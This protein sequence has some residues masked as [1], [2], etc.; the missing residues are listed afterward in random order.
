MF[1]FR[2][3]QQWS[4]FLADFQESD[5]GEGQRTIGHD[6]FKLHTQVFRVIT[7]LHQIAAPVDGRL[8]R[9][10]HL[11]GYYHNLGHDFFC[12]MR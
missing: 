8:R 3:S 12:T 2:Q 5:V 6:A 4:Y 11:F 10:E 7:Y 1:N 9:M